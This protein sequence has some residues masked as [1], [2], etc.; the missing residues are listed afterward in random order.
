M[1]MVQMKCVL[2]TLSPIHVGCD[3]VYEPTGFTVDEPNDR[4]V[5][6][7]PL[8]FIQ[9]LSPEDLKQF[10]GICQKGTVQSILEIY[11]FLNRRSAQGRTVS[12]CNGFMDHYRQVLSLTSG[13]VQ[14][15]LNS[16]RIERTS[17]CPM[18]QRPY[19]PGSTVKGALRTAYLNYLAQKRKNGVKAN[20]RGRYGHR[21]LEQHLLHLDAFSQKEQIPKDPFRL[22]KV[23]DFM[24]V[25]DVKTKVVYGVNKKKKPSEHEGQGP[26]QIL[27]V[28]LPGARFKGEITVYSPETANA[29]SYEI[30]LEDLM[31]GCGDF[32]SREKDSEERWLKQMGAKTVE[33]PETDEP[34]LVR[35]GRHSGAECV[36]VDGYRDIKIKGKGRNFSFKE[37]TTTLWLASETRKPNTNRFLASFGWA[38]LT[39]RTEKADRL[40][41]DAEDAFQADVEA[42]RQ[43]E[44]DALETLRT[45]EAEERERLEQAARLK[46]E[47]EKAE[48][49]RIAALEA[50]SPEE[51]EILEVKDPKT[52]ENRVMEI[53]KR[54]GD[55]SRENRL[56]LARAFKERWQREDRWDLK[57]KQKKS[58]QGKKVNQ[59][60][61]ILGE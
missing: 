47:E 35:V 49:E 60:K 4:L 1:K 26:P 34:V 30:G 50:M 11:R 40:L 22:V 24:P 28:I 12:V 53:F 46:A 55:F 10:S 38:A 54:M 21:V 23:S 6:F 7:D 44:K 58:K 56:K 19:I 25:G 9:G 39:K 37:H 29:V 27:E 45:R 51:R 16:F 14:N 20:L 2:E 36:T 18:D 15:E 33:L 31:K 8:T 52:I 61:A 5:I 41:S 17:F 59:I 43:T 48:A 3:D 57:G 13:K 42:W 32:F